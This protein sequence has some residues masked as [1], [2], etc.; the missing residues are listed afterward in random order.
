M[1]HSLPETSP[2]APEAESRLPGE[3][4]STEQADGITLLHEPSDGVPEIVDSPASLAEVIEAFASGHGPV[5]V[6]AERASGY[7]YGQRTYLVQMRRRS[8]RKRRCR[9]QSQA[10]CA[11]RRRP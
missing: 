4:A 1:P 3:E 7:R 8:G 11:A 9:S 6:D 10:P 2:R 5:A